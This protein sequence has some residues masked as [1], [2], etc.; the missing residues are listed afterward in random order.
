MRTEA[1]SDAAT[2]IDL[3]TSEVSVSVEVRWSID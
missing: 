2:T 1:A 3:G